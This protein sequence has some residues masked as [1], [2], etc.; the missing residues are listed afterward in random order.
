MESIVKAR[1]LS[2]FYGSFC[3]L[4]HVDLDIPPGAITGLIGPNGAGKTTTLKALLGLCDFEGE[5]QVVG[6]FQD[7]VITRLLPLKQL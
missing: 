4:D 3:A 1:S 5:L 6:R 2:K 7:P